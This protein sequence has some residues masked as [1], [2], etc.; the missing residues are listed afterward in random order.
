MTASQLASQLWEAQFYGTGSEN[1]LTFLSRFKHIPR[2]ETSKTGLVSKGE[3]K[4]ML[5][6]RAVSI[7]G[8]K[9]TSKDVV[10]FPI[11]EMTFFPNSPHAKCSFQWI[12][13]KQ[14]WTEHWERSDRAWARE[15]LE[16][17][18]SSI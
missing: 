6:N 18:C 9:P 5:D 8:V 1:A 10:T 16:G 4:R 12:P 7:N 2:S 11:F 13:V 15:M 17:I 14:A 3:R